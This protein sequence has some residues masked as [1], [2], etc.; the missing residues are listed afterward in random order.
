V[1]SQTRNVWIQ[2]VVGLNVNVI[3]EVLAEDT[4]FI[5]DAARGAQD[6]LRMLPCECIIFSSPNAGNFKH[7]AS[8]NGLVRFVCPNW[9]MEE[10]Q[11]LAHGSGDR[12]P[13]EEVET[14]FERC[15]GSPRAVVANID[16][17]V[18]IAET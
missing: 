8:A 6:L 11:R 4:V 10:L 7:M 2:G 16:R 13:P 3:P 15:G 5:Y 1:F 18:C 14:R 17:D 9:T 12:F